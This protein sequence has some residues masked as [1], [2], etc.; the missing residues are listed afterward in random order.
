MTRFKII[1]IYIVDAADKVA[2]RQIFS[3]AA[4]QDV[5][6]ESIMIKEIETPASGSL[7]TTLKKQ[8]IG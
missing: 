8:V 7:I 3:K 5:F 4:D 1:K 6:L 2:A